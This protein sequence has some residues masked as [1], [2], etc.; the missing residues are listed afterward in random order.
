VQSSILLFY[1]IKILF[2]G[3]VR[4]LLGLVYSILS[5]ICRERSYLFEEA[6]S[7]IKDSQ[8]ISRRTVYQR[9]IQR[10][11]NKYFRLNPRAVYPEKPSALPAQIA[12]VHSNL[13]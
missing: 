10:V 13:R 3:N 9:R 5:S 1:D 7:N 4:G 6:I 2:F 8:N 12:K 11:R